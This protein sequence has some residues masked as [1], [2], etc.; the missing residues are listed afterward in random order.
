MKIDWMVVLTEWAIHAA[1]AALLVYLTP[2][3]IG[4]YFAG[5]AAISI[6]RANTK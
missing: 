6:L 1:V 3:N 4:A 5:V 2:L